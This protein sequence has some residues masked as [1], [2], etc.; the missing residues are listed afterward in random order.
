MTQIDDKGKVFSRIVHKDSV[1]VRIQTITH[2]ITGDIYVEHDRR[3]KDELEFAE[4]FIAV[5]GAT[6][7]NPDGTKAYDVPFVTINRNHIVWLILEDDP[8]G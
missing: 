6:L 3:I 5:T 2:I 1:Y 7:Y 4:Q 8:H